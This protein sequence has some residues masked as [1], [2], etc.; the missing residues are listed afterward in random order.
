M[1]KRIRNTINT[2]IIAL[3]A[4]EELAAIITTIITI[5]ST[6]EPPLPDEN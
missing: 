4:E 5:Q 2:T 3:T 1:H 6:G